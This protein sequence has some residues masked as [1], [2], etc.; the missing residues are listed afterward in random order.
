MEQIIQ[1]QEQS[2]IAFSLLVKSQSEEDPVDLRMLLKYPLL[3]VPPSIGTPDGF[4]TKTNKATVLHYLLEEVDCDDLT[5]PQD[6]LFIQDGMALL[7]TLSNLPPTCGE[8]CLQIL[9][10]MVPKKNFVFSTD[11]YHE[12]SIKSQERVRRGISEKIILSGPATRKPY[13]FKMFLTNDDNKRQLSELLLKVWGSQLATS[14]LE[15]TETAILIV[16][17]KGYQFKTNEDK[18]MPYLMY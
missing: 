3:P 12:S 1:Y 14:R 17:G 6:A 9:D 15:K 4:Y 8:I 18:V 16:E 7:H 10:Q 2:S 5:Y 13:D 11:C